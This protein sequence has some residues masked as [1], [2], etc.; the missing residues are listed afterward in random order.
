M[1]K[2]NQTVTDFL[3]AIHEVNKMVKKYQ[4]HA[5]FVPPM[6]RKPDTLSI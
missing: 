3:K 5:I 4:T 6:K 2:L 1:S